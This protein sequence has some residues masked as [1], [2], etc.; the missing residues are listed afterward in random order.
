VIIMALLYRDTNAP[1]K[2]R[3]ELPVANRYTYGL[4]AEK[5]YRAIK[6]HGQILGTHCPMC[7]I[8]FV[9]PSLYCERCFSELTEWI[10][11][12]I[13]GELHTFTLLY[14]NLDGGYEENPQAIGVIKIGDGS[15]VHLL[16]EIYPEEIYI[17]M[18]VKVKFKPQKDRIGAITDIEYFYPA[19]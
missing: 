3:G 19:S 7:N 17:G 10:D 1:E 14:E 13:I 4:A 16:G 15:L 5:F 2:W 6:D 11:V 12:G 8:T 9:P 18:Q